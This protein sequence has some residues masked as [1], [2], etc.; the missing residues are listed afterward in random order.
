MKH[1]L[2]VWGLAKY[3]EQVNSQL[4]R[5]STGIIHRQEYRQAAHST[6]PYFHLGI[7]P[8]KQ[9]GLSYIGLSLRLGQ[10]T[11]NQLWGLAALS[12]TFVNDQLRITP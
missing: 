7:H 5:T 11:A 6:Q 4:N 1:L 3:L 12:E 10:L 2:K 8:Q 9:P